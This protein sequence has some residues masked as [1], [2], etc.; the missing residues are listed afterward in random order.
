MSLF[1]VFM[2]KRD[3]LEEKVKQKTDA[4]IA[5]AVLLIRRAV[6]NGED[7]DSI[8][9][10]IMLTTQALSISERKVVREHLIEIAEEASEEVGGEDIDAEEIVDT[11]WL[12]RGDEYTN[13]EDDFDSLKTRT[14]EVTNDELANGGDAYDVGAVAESTLLLGTDA[15]IVTED[16]RVINQAEIESYPNGYFV[17]VSVLD[18]HVCSECESMDGIE[19]PTEEMQIGVNCAP[20]HTSCRCEVEVYNGEY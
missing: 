9:E 1:G 10:D 14:D 12:D 8:M 13:F 4:L 17:N 16:T 6:E 5:S 7:F 18:D 2:E 20:F 3:E 15:I 19:I 11:K